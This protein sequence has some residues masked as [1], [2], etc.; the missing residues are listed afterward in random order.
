MNMQQSELMRVVIAHAL[1]L[2]RQGRATELDEMGLTD[3][4]VE[5]FAQLTE[6]ELALFC[7]ARAH[8][9]HIA[10]DRRCLTLQRHQFERRREEERLQDELLRCRASLPAM[11][12]LFG[13]NAEEYARRRRVLGLAATG[14]GR[15]PALSDEDQARAW[16]I[17]RAAG[18]RSDALRLL[19][20]GEAG[21]PLNSAW[22]LIQ[23]WYEA[24]E[25]ERHD[26]RS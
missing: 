3:E 18:G 13:M 7:G 11:H 14:N 4:D 21:I 20:V 22:P 19:A 5:F 23:Q 1:H 12:F 6:M 2:Q 26:R 10:V 24:E 25:E 9:L 15:P 17:W 16:H 8:C